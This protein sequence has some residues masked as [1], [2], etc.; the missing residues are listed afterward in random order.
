M[1]HSEEYGELSGII[2]QSS[3]YNEYVAL[4]LICFA[5]CALSDYHSQ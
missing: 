4:F 2:C 3:F 5:C 1:F